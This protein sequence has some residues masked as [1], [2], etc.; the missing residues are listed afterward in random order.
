MS[1]KTKILG[2]QTMLV[3]VACLVTGLTAHS[4]MVSSL[5]DC[6]VGKLQVIAQDEADAIATLTHAKMGMIERIATGRE[7]SDYGRKYDDPALV[8]Y[9]GKFAREFPRLAYVTEDGGEQ[10]K[11]ID[12]KTTDAL[13]DVSDTELFQDALWERNK[14]HVQLCATGTDPSS[15]SMG[16]ATCRQSFFDQFEGVIIG[17]APLSDMLAD[18]RNV[19]IGKTGFIAV[20]DQRG[21]ILSHPQADKLLQRLTAEETQPDQVIADAIAMKAGHGRATIAGVDGYVAYYPVEGTN[22]TVI[23]TLPYQEF[24]SAPIALR[25]IAVVVSVVVLFMCVTVGAIIASTITTGL[26][27]LAAVTRVLA[28][29]DLSHRVAIRTRDEIGTLGEAFNRMAE[30]LHGTIKKLNAEI[31]DRERAQTELR[32]ANERLRQA[33]SD[34]VQSEKMGMLGELA[35]GVAHEINTPTGAILNVS[36][37]SAK[38]L[39]E[40]VR[41]EMA[42]SKLPTE[43][44]QWLAEVVAKMPDRPT[45]CNESQLRTRRRQIDKQLRESGL[46]GARRLAEVIIYYGLAD[47]GDYRGCLAH[48]SHEP[49]LSALEHVA[50][51]KTAAEISTSSAEKIARIVLA[52]RFYARDAQV[53]VETLNINEGI[54]DTL[55]LLQSRLTR[56]G[57]VRTNLQP[58]LAPVAIGPELAQVWSNILTNAC[59]AIEE[60]GRTGTGII[61]VSSHHADG[62]VIVTI[63]NNGPPIPQEVISKIFD[64]FFTTKPVGKATG[65]GLSICAGIVQRCGGTL[66]ARNEP[67]RVV[68]E[69]SIPAYGTKRADKS[70][71]QEACATSAAGAKRD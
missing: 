24:M 33:Q 18:I 60:S 19:K 61:E 3:A 49:V 30:W 1:I 65:L 17:Y 25:N 44:R 47:D 27:R 36:A 63:A 4:M 10:V 67:D 15:L 56:V 59:D 45:P 28:R 35:A 16:F 11:L 62:P 7:V 9:L 40:L 12:G 37:D 58:N 57:E 21:V 66:S 43:T 70:A 39:K 41:L 20:A 31:K 5:R 42:I 13:E 64:P 52:L 54:E 71:R 6:Q 22:W 48:L 14:V 46:A 23:A 69:V 26:S 55:V 29:G 68:F 34:L 32:Q 8:Q 53:S 50:A 38:H 2:W 51:L